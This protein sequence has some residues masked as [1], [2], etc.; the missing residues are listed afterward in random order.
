MR[1]DIAHGLEQAEVLAGAAAPVHQPR[2]RTAYQTELMEPSAVHLGDL[3]RLRESV[4]LMLQ[5]DRKLADEQE[6]H[7]D[8]IEEHGRVIDQQGKV[9]LV[10]IAVGGFGYPLLAFGLALILWAVL[11]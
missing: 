5:V 1:R 9:L 4:G 2:G 6:R 10:V 3:S 7:A 8:L 11:S